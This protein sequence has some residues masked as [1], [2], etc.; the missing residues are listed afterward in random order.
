MPANL[1]Q[2]YLEAEARYRS[3]GSTQEK[4]ACL[5][6]MI[7]LLPK[8][9]GTEKMHAD[10]KSRLAKL[11]KQGESKG[12]GPA[13][14]GP[15]IS[16]E[17]EGAG[18]VLLLGPP[19]AGKSA[20]VATVS[21]APVEVTDYPFAT[22]KPV[23]GAM[24]YEDVRIQLVDMPSISPDFVDPNLP[25]LARMADAA[26]ICIDLGS[27][28][29]LDHADWVVDTLRD[30]R[31]TLVGGT[32]S[33]APK[34]GFKKLPHRFVGTKADHP[35]AQAAL[36]L[37]AEATGGEPIM[38]VSIHDEALLVRFR[39]MCFDLFGIVRVYS[40]APGKEPDKRVPF[41]LP[42]GS[43]LLDFAERVHR[44]FRDRLAFARV[45]GEDKFDGQRVA[46]DY[47]LLDRDVIELHMK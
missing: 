31:I 5:E 39:R 22:H 6:E 10:L 19:N 47:V 1:T 4:I 32:V 2:P 45:W 46:K 42:V 16:I 12:A 28:D 38:P 23:P 34:T 14:R 15:D 17:R 11:R 36:E 20:L 7:T 37:L 18:Q 33:D 25:Q 26:L 40:K 41:C 8:H 24:L 9:K 13:R 35:D 27:P 30:E 43:T 3:A 29:C 44:D 21:N